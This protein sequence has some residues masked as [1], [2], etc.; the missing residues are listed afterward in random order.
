[1]LTHI[2]SKGEQTNDG[3]IDGTQ[4]PTGIRQDVSELLPVHL[5]QL[6]QLRAPSPVHTPPVW[7]QFSQWTTAASESQW[8]AMPTNSLNFILSSIA[9]SRGKG[10]QCTHVGSEVHIISQHYR[11]SSFHVSALRSQNGL[12]SPIWDIMS[13]IILWGE[14]KTFQHHSSFGDYWVDSPHRT[15]HPCNCNTS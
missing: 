4:R 10:C 5:R 1:M 11:Y 7:R 3:S 6:V 9:R 12:P 2:K 14:L 13:L 8:T 15:N